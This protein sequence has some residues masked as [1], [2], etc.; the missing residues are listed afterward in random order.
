M[1]VRRF[2]RED[3][4]AVHGVFVRAVSEGAAAHYSEAER[5]AWAP[6]TDLP[7]GWPDRLAGIATFVSEEEGRITG[8]M[9]LARDGLLDLAFVLPERMGQGVAAALHARV[10][11]EAR[12]LGLTRLRTEASHLAR[13]FFLKHGW[14]EE[15]RQQVERRGVPITSFRMSRDLSD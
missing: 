6:V 5:L 3:A 9:A 11:E 7:E 14:V 8:F 12:A 13:S 15:A 4:V 10:L 2:R 1:R